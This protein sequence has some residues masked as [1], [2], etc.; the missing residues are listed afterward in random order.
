M[1]LSKRERYVAIGTIAAITLLA[2]DH[3]ALSPYMETRKQISMDLDR[4]NEQTTEAV[5]L[6]SRERRLRKIWAEMQAGG[7]KTDPSQAESETLQALLDWA[8]MAGVDLAAV[9]PEKTTQEGKFQVI[10]FNITG[11]ST[12]HGISRMLWLMETASIPVRV[13]DMQVTARKEGT[14]DLSVRL[15][16][17]ALCMPP[18]PK[19]SK[20]SVAAI[21]AGDRE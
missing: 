15:G 11:S 8:Q 5:Q 2:A 21:P 7:L 17:S 14:D 16:V 20:V 18:D 12:M 9:K 19:T 13:N 3:F 6:F 10:S 4:A 1:V